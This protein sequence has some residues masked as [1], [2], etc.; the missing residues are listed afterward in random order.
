MRYEQMTEAAATTAQ[1]W[2]ALTEVAD[3]P[4]W[5]TSMSAVQP[6]DGARLRPGDRYKIRQPR[7][8]VLVWRVTE[9]RAGESFVWEARSPG[10]RTVGFHR[11]DANPGGGT[12]ITIGV[13]HTGPLAG[14]VGALTGARTRRYL[15]L[16]AAGLKAASE[17]VAAGGAAGAPA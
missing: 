8:P 5:T 7:L 12:R 3:W 6:L 9:V 16:E 2:T 14:L 10:V 13:E 1:A 15:E 11:L 4:R 17:D